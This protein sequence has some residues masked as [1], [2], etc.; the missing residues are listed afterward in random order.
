MADLITVK[1]GLNKRKGGPNKTVKDLISVKVTF[2]LYS[3][4]VPGSFSGLN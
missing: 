4:Y 1:G 2:H 3:Y